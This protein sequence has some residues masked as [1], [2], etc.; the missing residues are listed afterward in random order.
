MD[1]APTRVAGAGVLDGNRATGS[2]PRSG[3][4][5]ADDVGGGHLRT[6]GF[7]RAAWVTD[8]IR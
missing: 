8:C 6:G 1:A 7:L 3:W 4:R 5:A 2:T